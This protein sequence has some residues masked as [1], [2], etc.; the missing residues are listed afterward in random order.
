MRGS[1]GRRTLRRASRCLVQRRQGGSI[2]GCR[3][4]GGAGRGGRR[5]S[6]RR[7]RE[8]Q[9]GTDCSP[10]CGWPQRG[11]PDPDTVV[12]VV[13]EEGDPTPDTCATCGRVLVFTPL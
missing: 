1:W 11:A 9:G 2:P 7:A 5:E 10:A 4:G 6:G 3:Q 12:F 8:R 13:A